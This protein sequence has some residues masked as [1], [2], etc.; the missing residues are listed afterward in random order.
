MNCFSVDIH[1]DLVQRK[2]GL[3]KKLLTLTIAECYN[4]G[5]YH[6]IFAYEL[7]FLNKTQL[8]R[9]CLKVLILYRQKMK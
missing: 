3:G 4:N 6:Q 7:L 9:K 8:H 1:I 2:R 5:F